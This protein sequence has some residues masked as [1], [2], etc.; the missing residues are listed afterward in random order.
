[1]KKGFLWLVTATLLW[2]G[3]YIAGRILAPELPA[4]AVNA[5]R[6][7]VS[8][9]VLWPLLRLSGRN[10]SVRT[11]WP[12]YLTMG[13]IG[14]FVFSGLTYLGLDSLPAAQ[15]GMISG[16]MPVIILLLSVAILGERPSGRAWLGVVLSVGGILVLMGA[17]RSFRLSAGDLEILGS[18]VAWGLYT[19]LGK[20]FS[21]DLDALTLTTGAAIFGAVP[22]ALAAL[23]TGSPTL[24]HLTSVGWASLAYVS[25]L[26]SVLAY[27]VWTA[28][29]KMVGAARSAPFMNLLPV[30]TVIMGVLL[31]G[32][33]LVLHQLIGGG[34]TILGAVVAGSKRTPSPSS[35]RPEGI[36]SRVGQEP[37][38]SAARP[39][40][41]T[42]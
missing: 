41:S 5:I 1:M 42:Q 8:S 3:N 37:T 23:T 33:H 38:H 9:F 30:W 36:L 29:V 16:T 19:V 18:A 12:R 14:M 11:T 10:L 4:L 15:A 28:G 20:R 34:V 7:I 22:S 24:W 25:T 27:F 13:F 32:E 40:E 2:S 17:G 31:L 35:I 6:W 21:Q 26:S 39:P